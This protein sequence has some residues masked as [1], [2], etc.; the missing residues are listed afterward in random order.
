MSNDSVDAAIHQYEMLRQAALAAAKTTQEAESAHYRFTGALDELNRQTTELMN[1][2]TLDADAIHPE[3][4]DA[5]AAVISTAKVVGAWSDQLPD[6][7]GDPCW[8][9]PASSSGLPPRTKTE[10]SPCCAVCRK[11]FTRFAA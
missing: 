7:P 11:L 4:V 6:V 9:P 2:G 8:T 5:V 10:R 3:L 1:R